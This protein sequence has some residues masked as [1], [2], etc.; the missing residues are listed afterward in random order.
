ANLSTALANNPFQDNFS[1]NR[2]F[3]TILDKSPKQD[4]IET[5]LQ[6]D[7]GGEQ[8]EIIGDIF[9]FYLPDGMAKSKISNN[10]IENK[11]QVKGTGRNR[12]TI[13]RVLDLL[14]E[15]SV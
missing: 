1:G 6:M 13:K 5:L 10:F 9:Y 11:L 14:R 4:R 7:L 2:V 8:F 15:I 12:N 3:I